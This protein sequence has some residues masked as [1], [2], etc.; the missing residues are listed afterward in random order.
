[1]NANFEIMSQPILEVSPKIKEDK[2]VSCSLP[3]I[4]KTHNISV[5]QGLKPNSQ[6]SILLQDFEQCVYL[7]N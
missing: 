6:R 1:M 7:R 5:T 2:K 3:I 4:K